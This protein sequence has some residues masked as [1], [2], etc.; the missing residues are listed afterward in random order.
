MIG[1]SV[2]NQNLTFK[3]D[4]EFINKWVDTRP[5]WGAL[6]YVTY[7]RTYARNIET[8]PERYR[9]LAERFNVHG[10]EEWWLTVTRVVEGTYRIQERHCKYYCLKWDHAKARE[11]AEEMFKLI[12]NFKFLPPGRGLWMMG[13]D[14][15][16][17]RGGAAL[18]NCGFTS[19]ENID[20]DFSGP[21]TFLMDMSMLGVGVGGDC[22]GAGKVTIVEP[23]LDNNTYVVED[24]RV[25]WVQL[26]G[27]VL[28]AFVGKET[29][30]L[31]IDYSNV[32]GKG[33]P[34]KG[35]GGTAS[36]PEPLM[37]LVD[38]L[39]GLLR[40]RVGDT[41]RSSDIVDI[42]NMIG[43]AVVAGNVR[44]T[45]EIM[46][47]HNEDDTFANL[48]SPKEHPQFIS[49]DGNWYHPWRWASN[50]SIFAEVG[51]DYSSAAERT[52][53]NGEPGYMWLDN[54]R[55]YGRMGRDPDGSDTL[56]KGGNPCLEQTLES[57]ELCCLVET[58]PSL[59]D[60]YAEY[61]R[62][63]KFAYLYAKT[64]TL[65][66]T[67]DPRTNAVLLKNRRIGTSMTGIVQAMNKHGRRNLFNWCNRGY[68]FL[69]RLDKT[70]SD[71]LAIPKSI[72][73]TSVKPSGTVS[74][75]AG[76][77]PGIHFPHSKY[78]YR[79]IR[80][81]EDSPMLPKLKESGYRCVKTK[82]PNT[83]AVYFP[84]EEP[85]FDRSKDDVTM[86][87]QLELAA[88]MQQYWADNQVSV[89]VTFKKSESGD[90][91]HA[92][93]LYETRLKGV[94]FLPQ[95]DHGF[96]H[97]PYQKI[98][99]TEYRKAITCIKP[100]DS[101]DSDVKNEVIDKFCDGDSCII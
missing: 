61:E 67:H 30:P 68:K 63:L 29:L 83:I 98:D 31:C 51:Q 60:D 48:K 4:D 72:K 99:E 45:A 10:T 54:A 39:I 76:V 71:W 58:F 82:E 65:L 89:T 6:G 7:K 78:Y 37:E 66:H 64:V 3:L 50:N 52:S 2:F 49:E 34:I 43:K 47:G 5:K 9:T 22:K 19:T 36:G 25:G 73:I 27:K 56:A 80:F 46:F 28:D 32:R 93:E 53:L 24:S 74:L 17:E 92:L 12:F 94:S 23:E 79:V 96:E 42:F 75:L 100:I 1:A 95:S 14:Y 20:E 85:F 26:I 57:F 35:F 90:I 70:Y 81:S 77:T 40:E 69:R 18:N 87:E 44:R 33:E 62:T 13:T 59:H 21:F 38:S 55:N 84:I 16:M 88:Q 15:I 101:F 11:S 86:W 8:L 91:R 41:I 97:A